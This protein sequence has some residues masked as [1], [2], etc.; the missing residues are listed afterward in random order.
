MARKDKTKQQLL[1]EIT[2]LENRI[3]ELENE[4][5]QAQQDFGERMGR[6]FPQ[7][8]QMNEAIY[9]IFDR[10]YEF[11]NQQFA[12]LFGVTQEEVCSPQFDI[13]ELIAPE[14]RRFVREKYTQGF[15]GDYPTQQFEFTGMTQDGKKIV[16]ENFLLFIPYKWGV[17]MHGMLRNV[18]MR[19][20]IDEE[21]QRE[22]EDL[23]V[24]LN[25]I[26]S[27]IFYTDKTH[28]FTRVNEAFCKSLGLPMEQVI[29]KTLTELFPNLPA[30]QLAHFYRVNEKV[31]A[32]GDSQR[33]IIEF[34]PSLRGRRWIQNDRIPYFNENGAIDG[35]MCLAIDISDLRETEEK[36]E[37]LSF[38]DVLTGVYNRAYFE[39]EMA[40]LENSRQFPVTFITIQVDDLI[41]VNGRDGIAAGNE[42]LRRTADV[43]KVLRTEDA[44]ARI[45]G[46]QFAVILPLADNVIGTNTVSRLKD[47]LNSH[48]KNYSGEPLNL[49]FGVATGEK[50]S[51]LSS[52]LKKAQSN[53]Q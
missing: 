34:F 47:A 7:L 36:L 42:L 29:G 21:L 13:M 53:L 44:A 30:D 43:M 8:E 28:R 22:R 31:M 25:S 40:R 11:V 12:D 9:V 35:L 39:E 24:V 26:P 52:V 46:D 51:K 41:L 45:G 10:K 16:C 1:D 6:Y 23:Q 50:D 15:R 19:K 20:R 37:Y 17:A 33:G 18:T 32:T 5:K 4:A 38:H 14:S 49:S 2:L 48:N 27:S 3:T